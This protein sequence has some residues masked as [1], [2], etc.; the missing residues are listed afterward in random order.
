MRYTSSNKN[1]RVCRL[2]SKGETVS[3]IMSLKFNNST[4]ELENS[5]MITGHEANVNITVFSSR[6][7]YLTHKS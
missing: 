5:G 1:V 6:L 2:G 4:N 7:D 3:S